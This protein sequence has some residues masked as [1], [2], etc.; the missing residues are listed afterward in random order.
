M[1][2][3]KLVNET[4]ISIKIQGSGKWSIRRLRG[5]Y[6]D[7][8]PQELKGI[9]SEEEFHSVIRRINLVTSVF[10][11]CDPAYYIGYICIPFTLGLSLF[12]PDI[13]S[14]TPCKASYE[15]VVLQR[16]FH[17]H[18]WEESW[19]IYEGTA[20]SGDLVIFGTGGT[21]N[22][23]GNIVEVECCLKFEQDYTLVL[24]DSAGDGWGYGSESYA[25]LSLIYQGLLFLKTTMKYQTNSYFKEYHQQFNFHFDLLPGSLWKYSIT[26]QYTPLWI[27]LEYSDTY[28]STAIPSILSSLYSS[29]LINYSNIYTSKTN[30][31]ISNSSTINS[32]LIYL[33]NTNNTRRLIDIHEI[34]TNIDKHNMKSIMYDNNRNEFYSNITTIQSSQ[35]LLNNDNILQSNKTL[36]NSNKLYSTSSFPTIQTYTVY[37]R[38]LVVLE[39]VDTIY[40]L[41]IGIRTKTSFILYINGNEAYRYGFS[42]NTI[43]PTTHA[44]LINDDISYKII[45][46]PYSKFSSS[47]SSTTTSS[48]LIAVEVHYHSDLFQLNNPFDCFIYTQ[49]GK[50][51]CSL[52]NIRGDYSC[53]PNPPYSYESCSMA[54]DT[55]P[56]T[57]VYMGTNPSVLIYKFD[58]ERREWINSYSIVSGNDYP[59]RDPKS[60]YIHGSND[61]NTWTFLDYQE[62]QQFTYRRQSKMYFIKS[63][64]I[65]FNYYKMTIVDIYET[66][67]FTQLS[68]LNFYTCNSNILP[69]GLLYSSHTFSFPQGTTF[70]IKPISS[71]YSSYTITPSITIDTI[72]FNTRTGILEGYSNEVFIESYIISS[73]DIYG[74]TNSFEI[75][76]NIFFCSQPLFTRVDILKNQELNTQYERIQL[77][78]NNNTIYLD[79]L[80]NPDEESSIYNLC[81]PSGIYTIVL[82]NTNLNS[83]WKTKSNVMIYL[84]YVYTSK[85]KIHQ[86]TLYDSI[87]TSYSFNTQYLI[88]PLSPWKYHVRINAGASFPS[89]WYKTTYI[90]SNWFDYICDYT[91]IAPSSILLFRN[92]IYIDN[93][94]LYSSYELRFYTDAG[95]VVYINNINVYQMNLFNLPID[96]D[97]IATAKESNP[98][99]RI[100]EGIINTFH[101]GTNTIAIGIV[102]P[103][104]ML[105]SIYSHID[106]ILRL[107]IN[108]HK[109]SKILEGYSFSSSVVDKNSHEYAFDTDLYTKWIGNYITSNYQQYIGYL[110]LNR[111]TIY[112]NY[113][114]I[115]VGSDSPQY[116]PVSW[117]FQGT[118]DGSLFITLSYEQNISW[119]FRNQ[120]QCFIIPNN[121]TTYVGFRLFFQKPYSIQPNYYYTVSEIETF[122][123]DFQSISIPTFQMSPRI[124]VAYVGL[125]IPAIQSSSAYFRQYSIYPSLP[126]PLSLDSSN[127]YINGIANTIQEKTI[128]TITA[129]DFYNNIYTT[130]I[131]LEIILCSS[132]NKLFSIQISFNSNSDDAG[133][134]L[135]NFMTNEV[136]S[137]QTNFISYSIQ[138]FPYC[139]PSSIYTLT[140]YDISNG[141]WGDASFSVFL[142]NSNP[143]LIGSLGY[144]ESPKNFTFNIAYNIT[145]EYNEWRYYNL[146]STLSPPNDW[147]LSTFNENEWPKAVA[148]M[149]PSPRGNTQY[150][151]TKFN[152]PNDLNAFPA[153][154]IGV[155]TYEG[156]IVYINGEEI[157]RVEI[158]TTTTINKPILTTNNITSYKPYIRLI[159]IRTVTLTQT[160]I[161]VFA[162]EIH[163]QTIS[164]VS[165]HFDAYLRFV[166]NQE[167]RSI[168]G[169]ISSNYVSSNS[170]YIT[171]LVDNNIQ[172]KF[173]TNYGCLNTILI[174]TYE[175]NR[176]ECI[177]QYTIVSAN[178]CNTRHPSGWI[179]EAYND[180]ANAWDVLDIQNNI[181]FTQY[182]QEKYFN[183]YNIIP[184]NQYRLRV[185]HCDNVSLK[186]SP[187]C[188][189]NQ[190]QLSEWSLSIYSNNNSYCLPEDGFD[191]VYEGTYAY[192]NCELYYTGYRRRLCQN[193]ILLEEESTCRPSAPTYLNYDNYILVFYKDIDSIYYNAYIDAI[194]L[195]YTISPNLPIGLY[196]NNTTGQIYGN[197]YIESPLTTYIISASNTAGFQIIEIMIIINIIR[198]SEDLFW[199]SV[200]ANTYAYKDCNDTTLYEGYIS[201]YCKPIYPPQWENPRENCYLKKPSLYYQPSFI[202]GY[203]GDLFPS[204]NIYTQG[205]YTSSF[206][207][208]PSL[209]SSLYFDDSTGTISG[210][211]KELLNMNY[212]INLSNSA[213]IGETQIYISIEKVFCETDSVIQTDEN[214]HEY[215]TVWNRTERDQAYYVLC[216]E[217]L[218]GIQLRRCSYYQYGKAIW[219]VIDSSNCVSN[220][221]LQ[222]L[223]NTNN[224]INGILIITI[225]GLTSTSYSLPETKELLRLSLYSYI[226]PYIIAKKYLQ[227]I[228]NE[229]NNNT[230][231]TEFKFLFYCYQDYKNYIQYIISTI[232]LN[233]KEYLSSCH[234]ST[235]VYLQSI[236]SITLISSTFSNDSDPTLFTI[237][238]LIGIVILLLLLLFLYYCYSHQKK[239]RLVIHKIS[240]KQK[241]KIKVQKQKRI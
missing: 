47:S 74:N 155:Y 55:I 70:S 173:F 105:S 44:Q 142:E 30:I 75:Q 15:T 62:N 80:N 212:T 190:F 40:L 152:I 214:N 4:F 14:S 90:D 18:W 205:L 127:G 161:N 131:Q 156:M 177:N 43:S 183:F 150:Y 148:N 13:F 98:V 119:E 195:K 32:S 219:S 224:V 29:S 42:N 135:T 191:G 49:R 86:F 221:N 41:E 102:Y 107:L 141:G 65:S 25:S 213:G 10:W 137:R 186:N 206:T 185:T 16:I 38:K 196:L 236:T 157:F 121:N 52:R 210:I 33:N 96:Y 216:S 23:K 238:I 153:I 87:S 11:S 27:A 162:A 133:F 109:N 2:S 126:T 103:S 220:S 174:Y 24:M 73:L 166:Y 37:F 125:Y 35:L 31:S 232:F 66:G 113:Y 57:K 78:S 192:K 144:G 104:N 69:E 122:T 239:K 77:L 209:P 22:H 20:V 64:Q 116:D 100:I 140:L 68:S 170:E 134:Y 139:I 158:D 129:Y 39:E 233:S 223:A 187:Q 8:Y 202:H 5:K 215:L 189:S 7:D 149:L 94:S 9:I 227:I 198:C 120:K 154:E 171:N 229:Y 101:T 82:S 143:I 180:I 230:K 112:I 81:I 235:N 63:N 231:E 1:S 184:Y 132:N 58:N 159:N 179:L 12:I 34:S 91:P 130:S 201:R 118:T 164:A 151:R 176:K 123:I 99:W 211:P 146:D 3:E 89:D 79:V 28:W 240:S 168:N 26:P 36:L 136:V 97:S 182:K 218:I 95:C 207:I 208:T 193:G 17:E 92:T 128:Y 67:S 234:N 117:F 83:G 48:L 93:L 111:R 50:D 145:L 114:C 169:V 124:I 51:T 84:Y 59:R 45:T 199:P 194:N 228:D 188:S 200:P 241:R 110:F 222:S 21:D 226:K 46:L 163:R 54:F 85:Y 160:Q 225:Y 88:S 61:N 147:M 204:L 178:D 167:F 19:E 115:R 175:D 172:T 6:C 71:G 60:W 165:G 197:P 56:Y 181:F 106:C 72:L 217:G 138:T 76:I 108:T 53:S 203:V 237:L